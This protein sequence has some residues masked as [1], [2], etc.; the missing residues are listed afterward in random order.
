MEKRPG[1]KSVDNISGS[2][3]LFERSIIIISLDPSKTKEYFGTT[4]IYGIDR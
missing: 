1:N 3:K 2:L 4:P